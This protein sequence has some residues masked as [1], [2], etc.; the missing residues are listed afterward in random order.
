L[1]R[2]CEFAGIS[3]SGKSTLIYELIKSNE[4]P[5]VSDAQVVI[6]KIFGP[7]MLRLIKYVPRKIVSFFL[8]THRAFFRKYYIKRA[9]AIA[10]KLLQK[11]YLDCPDDVRNR[12]LRLV[13]LV[14]TI[15]WWVRFMVKN[16]YPS[17]NKPWLVIDEGLIQKLASLKIETRSL[18]PQLQAVTLIVD[19]HVSDEMAMQRIQE[20]FEKT[21]RLARRHRAMSLYEIFC[22]QREQRMWLNRVLF[23]DDEI[24]QKRIKISSAECA[25]VNT[26]KI[27]SALQTCV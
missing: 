17:V 22:D 8:K 25:S 24:R 11:N 20:R 3:G 27:L 13:E 1:L 21:N 10:S 26:N 15:D 2:I 18:P 16:D 4:V 9:N 23:L 12:L 5:I 19:V 14:D 7:F 6:G